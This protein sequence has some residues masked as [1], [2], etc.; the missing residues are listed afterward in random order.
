VAEHPRLITALVPDGNRITLYSDLTGTPARLTFVNF[1]SVHISV[2]AAIALA[3]SVPLKSWTARARACGAALVLVFLVMLAVCVVQI[4]TAAETSARTQLG[5]AIHTARQSALLDWLVR[6]SSLMAVFVLPAALFLT[7]YASLAS[8]VE[9]PDDETGR[10]LRWAGKAVVYLCLAGFA[11]CGLLALRTFSAPVVASAEG[12]RRIADLNPT[13]A[14]ARF[15]LGR[16]LETRGQLA[17]AREAYESAIATDPG[18]VEAYLGAGNVSSKLAEYDRAAAHF[19][20]ALRRHPG[21]RMAR[22]GLAA[23]RL[24]RGQYDQAAQ[25]YA[26][27]LASDPGDA[28]AEKNLGITLVRLK[29]RCDALPHLERSLALDPSLAGDEGF[30]AHVAALRSECSGRD[31]NTR[32]GG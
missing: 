16:D 31:P 26:E 6:K 1:E 29:R 12:L 23:T 3:L 10:R 13:S 9:T 18:L 20:E 27:I 14:V 28:S 11:L 17:G 30:G 5:L 22:R 15:N 2:V 7:S 8:A 25:S 24:V 4:E 32:S 21:D 19:E